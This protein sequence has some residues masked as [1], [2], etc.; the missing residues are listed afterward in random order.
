[1][2][3]SH[4][5]IVWRL[6]LPIPAAVMI[7][8]AG[9]WFWLPERVGNDVT[10]ATIASATQTANQF[11]TIRGYYTKNVIK[12]AVKNGSLKPSFDHAKE[13]NGIPLPATLIHDLSKQLEKRDTRVA[14]Y[15][16]FPFPVRGERKLDDFQRSAWQALSADP[17]AVVHRRVEVDGRPMIR[18]AIAD[19]MVADACVNCHNTHPASPKTDWKLGDVRGVLEVASFIDGPLAAGGNLSETII[20]A[21]IGAGVLL[22]L[23]SLILARRVAGPVGQLAGAISALG[24]GDTTQRVEF[25]HRRDEIG[26]IARALDGLRRSLIEVFRLKTMIDEM[27]I[28]V[29]TCDA[30]DDMRI[31]YVNK[32]GLASLRTL[33]PDL[34]M[35]ADEAKGTRIGALGLVARGDTLN[36]ELGEPE[37]MAP[38]ERSRLGAETLDIRYSPIRDA[39]GGYLGPMV[40][41][42]LVTREESLAQDFDQNVKGVVAGLSAAARQMQ[43]TAEAMSRTSAEA[44]DMAGR[45]T[46]ASG[47]TSGNV[48][49]VASASEQLSASIQEISG[50]VA[51]SANV[52]EGASQATE[53]AT[54]RVQGLVDASERIGQVVDL[55]NDIANQTNLLA[56]NATIEAARAGEAGK[57]F[58]VV[59]AEVKNLASQTARATED[60]AEQIAGI[61]GATGE[62]VRAIEDISGTID[63]LNEISSVVATAIREQSTATSEIS[64][65]AQA[66]ADGTVTVDEATGGLSE[67]TTVVGRSAGEVLD[68]SRDLARQAESLQGE[69]ERFLTEMRAA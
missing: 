47:D 65:S 26:T 54:R 9:L 51:S 67:A 33:Q 35:P 3:F 62:A 55:I 13:A 37:T 27:P 20:L 66:A 5:S 69:V 64:A 60:I 12:K 36:S 24:A 6:I 45:V 53:E 42:Q 23:I 59:A 8:V 30:K 21:V 56:L 10:E 22:T 2:N 52:A 68:A 63:R 49:T 34:A 61:Q 44:G 40:T 31:D 4:H 19:R 38:R 39:E 15:S 7:L 32:S 11:K 58:A 57:G 48:Q 46:Q 25:A 43:D 18:V 16:A 29:M 14:L 50:Q 28:N 41:W 17:D 1:M